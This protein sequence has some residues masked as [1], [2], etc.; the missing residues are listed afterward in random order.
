MKNLKKKLG[1]VFRKFTVSSL[2]GILIFS[3]AA[4]QLNGNAVYA[5]SNSNDSGFKVSLNW[6]NSS[7]PAD[8]K[9]DSSTD[10]ARLVRLNVGYSNSSVDKGYEPGDLTITVP[11]IGEANRSGTIEAVSVAAD[12]ADSDTKERD[13]SY[14][15]DKAG[16]I[17][18]FTN[19]RKID[20]KSNFSGSFEILWKF[21]SRETKNGYSKE[22]SAALSSGEVT[23]NSNTV[24]FSYTSQKDM[25]TLKESVSKLSSPDGLGSSYKDYIWVNWTV[26]PGMVTKARGTS[27]L[28]YM[29][30]IL[31]GAVIKFARTEKDSNVSFYK[32]GDRY[33]V[34]YSAYPVTL[35]VGYPKDI[36]NG[37][38]IENPVELIGKYQDE[39]YESVLA[40]ANEKVVISA[41]DYDFVY[42]GGIVGIGKELSGS[43]DYIKYSDA[44][45]GSGNASARFI[46]EPVLINR[47]KVYDLAVYDDI[48]DAALNDGTFRKLNDNEYHFTS[49][50]VPGASDIKNGNG[51]G[52]EAD[53]Y[54]VEIYTRTAG[55]K[56]FIL[57]QTGKLGSLSWDV[58]L[59]NSTAGVKCIIKGVDVSINICN[60]AVNTV[61]HL[62]DT[63]SL[64][65]TS[66]YIRNL[67]AVELYEEGVLVNTADEENYTGTWA[68]EAAERDLELYGHYM[69]R[70][71][72]DIPFKEDPVY[73]YW[74]TGTSL[75][76]FKADNNGF[77]SSM[78]ISTDFSATEKGKV[79]KFSQYTILDKGVE[80]DKNSFD[81]TVSGSGLSFNNGSGVSDDYIRSHVNAKIL[82][83][84]R[85]SGRT[86]VRFDYDFSDYDVYVR[87][88]AVSS[89]FDL[90]V[91]SDSYMEYGE[92]YTGH[93]VSILH[94]TESSFL[95]QYSSGT[96]AGNYFGAD[97]DI[98]SDLD[99][100]GSTSETVTY[101]SNS[102]VIIQALSSYQELQKSVKSDYTDSRYLTSDAAVL[103]DDEYS[104]KLKFRTGN[105]GAKN[106][107]IYDELETAEGSEWKGTFRD[108]DLSYLEK[109]GYSPVVHYSTAEVPGELSNT[110]NWSAEKPKSN[111]EIKA[112]AVDLGENIVQANSLVYFTVT[113]VSPDN[114]NLI[115]KKTVNDFDVRFM[116]VDI[117]SGLETGQTALES[118]PVEVS[119]S[120]PI[121]TVESDSGN[122]LKGAVYTLYDENNKAVKD[123]LKTS[124]LGVITV[125]NIPFG[126]YYFLEKE[127]P[128]GYKLSTKKINVTLNSQRAEVTA[129]DDRLKG[130]VKLYKSSEDDKD[131]PVK[132][133]V[134]SLY[135][136][137]NDGD[138]LIAGGLKTDKDGMTSAVK[139]LEW[140]NY[141]FI[142]T[143]SAQG[144]DIN[145]E[146]VNFS[147]SSKNV[148]KTITAGTA[149]KQ[150]PAVLRVVKTDEASKE[151]V[152]NAHFDLYK[153]NG[154]TV[155]KDLKTDENGL[156]SING[157]TYGEYYLVET[158]NMGY[159]VTD[160]KISFTLSPDS[161]SGNNY[162]SEFDE[163]GSL[164][165]TVSVENTRKTGTA[166]LVKYGDKN[167]L[168]KDAVYTLYK[169]DGTL[170]KDTATN[171]EGQLSVSDLQWGSYYFMEKEAPDGYRLSEEKISFEIS[172]NNVESAV[173]VSA[174]D[175][176]IKGSAVLTKV[177]A[178]DKSL[179]LADA[180]YTL[181]DLKDNVV[182]DDLATDSSGEIKL[183]NLEWGSYYFLEKQAPEGYSL[184]DEKIRFSVNALNAEVT[185]K[186]TAEDHMEESYSITLTKRISADDCWSA[187]GSPTFIFK[188]EGTDLNGNNRTYHELVSF[189]EDYISSSVKDGTVE[190][191]FT[192]SGLP[193]G[194]YTASELSS[195]RYTLKDIINIQNGVK[196]NSTVS[197][198]LNTLNREGSAVFVNDKFNWKD[199]SHNDNQTNIIKSSVMPTGISVKSAITEQKTEEIDRG[200]LE[201]TVYYDDGSSRILS[202]D[203]Y[204]L[205][206]EKV[207]S[208]M[209]GEFTVTVS[210]TEKDAE[211]TDSFVVNV[212]IPV[213]FTA[214]IHNSS[215]QRIGTYDSENG[216][217]VKNGEIPSYAVIT[218]YTGTSGVVI[219]PAVIEGI[220]V[221]SVGGRVQLPSSVES[222]RFSEGI[223]RIEN[224]AF[225]GCT[226]LTGS[227][228]IPDS[229]ISIGDSAFRECTGF[230]GTLTLGSGIKTIGQYAFYNCSG[231]RGDLII[232][233]TVTDIK[234]S[235]FRGCS[236][237][238]GTLTLGNGLTG[239]G[240]YAF[241]GCTGFTG[242]LAVPDSVT[243]ID[244]FAFE[245]CSGFD[246]T[247]TL[248]NGLKT[249]EQC[250][251][252]NCAGFTGSLVIPDS[253]ISIGD[254]AFKN[255]TGFDGTLT[256][257]SGLETI[258]D[259]AFYGCAGFTGD[260]VIP[261]SV[262]SIGNSAFKNCTGF[263]GTLT[264]GSSLETIEDSAFYGC[265][266]FTGGL[267]IPGKVKT[268]SDH[269]FY[270]CSGLTGELIIPDSVT[271]VEQYAFRNCTGFNGLTLGSGLA[272]IGKYAFA[273][274][275]GFTGDLVIPDSVTV[276][277][278]YAFSDCTGFTGN[279]II[280]DSMTNIDTGVFD[281]CS[282]FK[283]TLTLG[284][285]LETIGIYAFYG[286]TGF[287]GNLIIPES[288]TV[289]ENYAVYNCKALTSITVLNRDCELAA[290]SIDTAAVIKGWTG[291]T[292]ETYASDRG[293][294]FESLDNAVVRN[295]A[296]NDN[297]AETLSKAEAYRKV[298]VI[299]GLDDKLISF[300]LKKRYTD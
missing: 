179:K 30:D 5:Q 223:E 300:F 188:I 114:S 110:D 13:W 98:W 194:S 221:R 44:V 64:I 199:Y 25:Y 290:N 155:S 173:V 185:Q 163:K 231:F 150:K 115:G 239:I 69:Q 52:L 210:Y 159:V 298:T 160:D 24:S 244:D 172:R 62:D 117:V 171:S 293:N 236:G 191:S 49:L 55:S 92:S 20:E 237:F 74:S 37:K 120:D 108:I 279:L 148:S 83:N 266:D 134:Y 205:N 138:S 93:G 42:P 178:D 101:Y 11:G 213:Q 262:I 276:I 161:L 61:F 10:E 164:V 235:T 253:V 26:S 58:S 33:R 146:K 27:G 284:N 206:P 119:L 240:I 79:G 294:I 123:D 165:C 274:C 158:G 232:P 156:I 251:F 182:S 214:D 289:I 209:N 12:N 211:M 218:G 73:R 168:L 104:Y 242:G 243:V 193:A 68:K 184:S 132:G 177:D 220:K 189:D 291:S 54:D 246:G 22:L 60:F 228:V 90:F 208:S 23:V 197:F 285:N 2:A 217:S 296:V 127:A 67:D 82:E 43:Q 31:D 192:V 167:T 281:N 135:K 65:D 202:D 124:S 116:S 169:G 256:L 215:G 131:I 136:A 29:A 107:V 89:S 97:T 6:N 157:L 273:N 1:K 118:N 133:A 145:N 63:D 257:G 51:L 87:N 260:L 241:D 99:G 166:V 207:D 275:T 128:E 141:Y 144:Y 180:V 230:N 45:S 143:A 265:T 187:H 3:A 196:S 40:S 216:L 154:R 238:D 204:T 32:K 162:S 19:N 95:P 297:F 212:K 195:I 295:T 91:S 181:Y 77:D 287:T 28:Y 71:Y 122:K 282:G 183:D 102:A 111:E 271:S 258:G 252:Y 39:S 72:A 278:S 222:V 18:T 94:D 248:G 7:D 263:N 15:Y 299:S 229:V 86:Y 176:Q 139:N 149:D 36:Y 57:F 200:L 224:S 277:E 140:G 59:P 227:L 78:K 270:K 41:E 288:V 112:I 76:D 56:E 38:E 70:D 34:N 121:G 264:L 113:M 247:L 280:P 152:S 106:L 225:Y 103:L 81:F 233:D 9:W 203:E 8:Y 48:L 100:D 47:G 267:L 170:L 198:D 153:S 190:K 46:L 175:D 137:D 254:S 142:E 292:A 96:D 261:D 272:G 174:E 219:F 4:G 268:I 226:D 75:N 88:S 109:K 249:I 286:C 129:Q 234:S 259:S 151:P 105:S 35:T 16:D 147:I 53:K 14:R 186:L 201:V 21:K 269:A 84:Y 50:V 80:I 125:R 283:G 66:G 85:G 255:C 250:A 17:Y 126:S 245:N 130:E